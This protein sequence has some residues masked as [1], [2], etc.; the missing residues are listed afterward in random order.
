M[1]G[2]RPSALGGAA[3]LA[4]IATAATAAPPMPG[5]PWKR[6][7][8]FATCSGRLAALAVRQQANRD[9]DW[10]HTR[11]LRDMFDLMLDAT[12]PAAVD[13]GVPQDE[14]LRWRSAGWTE[15]AVLLADISYS[16]DSHRA[17]RAAAAL[18]ARI[19]DCTGLLLGG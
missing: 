1:A 13:H 19:T 16:H 7:E 18:E 2:K 15:A 17:E 14:P 11:D 8:V 3:V 12:L 5:T 4:L 9:P 6:A 10:A